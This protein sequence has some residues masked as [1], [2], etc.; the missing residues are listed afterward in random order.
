MAQWVHF[1]IEPTLIVSQNLNPTFIISSIQCP[2]PDGGTEV[3]PVGDWSV[4]GCG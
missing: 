1:G 2:L 4:S 3:I